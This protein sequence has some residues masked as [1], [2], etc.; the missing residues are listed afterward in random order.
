[1]YCKNCGSKIDDDSKFCS[2]C[3][4][5]LKHKDKANVSVNNIK[6]DSTP[7]ID[8]E[9]DPSLKYDRTYNNDSSPLIIGIIL[10]ILTII[11]SRVEVE[12]E[13]YEFLFIVSFFIR[14]GIVIWIDNLAGKLELNQ[15]NWGLFAFFFPSIALIVIS[16]KKKRIYT[17][18][19]FTLSNEKKSQFNN[20]LASRY[21]NGKRYNDGLKL[22]NAAIKYDKNNHAAYDTKGMIRYYQKD[23]EGAL[24]D[25]NKSIE[26]DPNHAIKYYHRGYILKK[27]GLLNNAL[28]DWAN[29]FDLG[30][31]DAINPLKIYGNP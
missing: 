7:K 15:G 12:K 9:N 1:M 29:A 31:E 17:P 26:L 4:I 20:N 16:F 22:V 14:I 23:Y 5:K 25:L 10:S 19:Y 6:K 13:V 24:K 8:V 21:L 2:E 28:E 30:F 3:G 11:L 27:L 18:N